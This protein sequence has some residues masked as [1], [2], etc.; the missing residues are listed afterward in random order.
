MGCL[1]FFVV[2]GCLTFDV[3]ATLCNIHGRCGD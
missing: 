1:L 3:H 2:V